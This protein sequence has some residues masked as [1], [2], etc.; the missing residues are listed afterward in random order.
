MSM[1]KVVK[2]ETDSRFKIVLAAAQ[3]ANELAAGAAPL[4]KTD[5]KKVSTIALKEFAEGK[6]RYEDTKKSKK[7]AG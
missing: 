5:S 1:E 6:V 2:R 7:V 3:R 4:V